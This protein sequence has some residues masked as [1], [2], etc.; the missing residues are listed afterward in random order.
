MI[1]L[2]I[3]LLLALIPSAGLI[4]YF[5][6]RTRRP[7]PLHRL[8]AAFFLGFAAVLPAVLAGMAISPLADWLPPLSG[9]LRHLP[10]HAFRAFLIAGLLE[11][12]AKMAAV[13]G[14]LVPRP[15]FRTV[16]DGMVYT[17]TVS[18]G[19]AFFEN[20]LYSLG[21]WWVILIRGVT[22]VPLHAGASG[23]M[24]YYLG[25]SALGEERQAG[26]GL[27]LA[28]LIHGL[29][30]FLLFTHSLLSWL[31]FPLLILVLLSLPS[32][33]SAAEALDRRREDTGRRL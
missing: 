32:L 7:Q 9:P 10:S 22:A 1:P 12:G 30:D 19:F 17:V 31:V 8:A 29:Y 14:V 18:L 27:L 6:R 26:R 23:I 5:S 28:V 33:L 4:L 11:E 21:P 15:F 16:S 13:S 25:C 20:L 24:G 3:N 2:T